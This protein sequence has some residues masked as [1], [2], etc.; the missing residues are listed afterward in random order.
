[1]R[2]RLKMLKISAVSTQIFTHGGIFQRFSSSVRKIRGKRFTN[3]IFS[4]FSFLHV[5]I[6][7]FRHLVSLSQPGSPG[8]QVAPRRFGPLVGLLYRHRIASHRARS[9]SGA[10]LA[11]DETPALHRL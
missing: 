1:M 6:F 10:A 7:V 5:F 9:L 8:I 2:M 4:L 11:A 3:V